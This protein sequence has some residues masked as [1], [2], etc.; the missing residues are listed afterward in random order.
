[1]EKW[2]KTVSVWK[3]YKLSH[4]KDSFL[5]FSCFCLFMSEMAVK[6]TATF[7]LFLFLPG[8]RGGGIPRLISET[9]HTTTPPCNGQLRRRCFQIWERDL[10]RM[11][12]GLIFCTDISS[13]F[14][15]FFFFFFFFSCIWF[16]NLVEV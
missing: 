7:F 13:S 9:Y 16:R 12:V 6:E 11:K 1:M 14:L 8:R 5:F 10:G 4:D 3:R 15:F 2:A